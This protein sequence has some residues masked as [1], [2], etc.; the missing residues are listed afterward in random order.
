MRVLGG[1]LPATLS[2]AYAEAGEDRGNREPESGIAPSGFHRF[3]DVCGRAETSALW[4]CGGRHGG[5]GKRL[6]VL[7]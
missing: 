1:E 2:Y 7:R 5:A 4:A 3:S 6:Y